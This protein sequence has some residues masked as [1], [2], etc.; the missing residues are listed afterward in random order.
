MV[1]WGGVSKDEIDSV[2][3]NYSGVKMESLDFFSCFD[4]GK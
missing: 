3:E 1:S 4:E 2:V